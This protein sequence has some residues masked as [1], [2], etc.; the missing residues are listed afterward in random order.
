MV[1]CA[2]QPGVASFLGIEP[3]ENVWPK[4][5]EAASFAGMKSRAEETAP[6]ADLGEWSNSGE[7]F[8]SARRG[9]WQTELSEENKALYAEVNSK[10]LDPELKAWAEN[11]GTAGALA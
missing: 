5:V 9:A 6:D 3:S 7:F 2:L 8:R 4:L 1:L 10:R 11:G